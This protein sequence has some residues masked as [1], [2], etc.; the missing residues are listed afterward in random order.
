ME[1]AT[2]CELVIMLK[3]KVNTQD[4]KVVLKADKV[5]SVVSKVFSVFL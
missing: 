3:R 5:N 2:G 1:P 4:A